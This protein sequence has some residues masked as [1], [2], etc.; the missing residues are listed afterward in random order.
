M[1]LLP[2]SLEPSCTSSAAAAAAASTVFGAA[3]RMGR[4]RAGA[5]TGAGADD[6]AGHVRMLWPGRPQPPHTVIRNAAT[7]TACVTRQV[8]PPAFGGV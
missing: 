3:D 4:F 6:K 5:G 8:E 1:R 7:R 2:L